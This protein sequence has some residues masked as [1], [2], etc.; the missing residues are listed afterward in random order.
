MITND[1]LNNKQKT[2]YSWRS[3][4]VQSHQCH[5]GDFQQ[6]ADDCL[7]TGQPF[8]CPFHS[9]LRP[10]L[11]NIQ[12]ISSAFVIHDYTGTNNTSLSLSTNSSI[13]Q[14]KQLQ[15]IHNGKAYLPLFTKLKCGFP[16][17]DSEDEMPSNEKYIYFFNCII[18]SH[19]SLNKNDKVVWKHCFISILF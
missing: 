4:W 14:T 19:Q 12:Y 8:C 15:H 16:V 6:T 5:E 7:D 13:S 10:F 11:S 2:T 1:N 3:L 17:W 18:E 9:T